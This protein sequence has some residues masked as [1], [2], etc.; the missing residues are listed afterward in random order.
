LLHRLDDDMRKVDAHDR[1]AVIRHRIELGPCRCTTAAGFIGNNQV[2][3]E[4]LLEERLLMPCGDIGF[5]A[6]S[7]RNDVV[8]GFR[9]K[10]VSLASYRAEA[11]SQC[12]RSDC[13]EK[14]FGSR[15]HFEFVLPWLFTWRS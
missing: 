9:R 12:R 5:T 14:R 6:G 1:I 15:Q 8:D 11:E 7:E 13:L 10:V 4:H 3:A 2:L